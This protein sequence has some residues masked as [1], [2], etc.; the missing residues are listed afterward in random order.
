MAESPRQRFLREVREMEAAV[1]EVLSRGL[2]DEALREALEALARRRWFREFSW[3]WAPELTPRSRVLFR[4]FLLN[5]LSAW[6]LDAKGK[7]LEPWK[8]PE[9]AGTLQRLLDEADR[10]DDVELFRRLYAWRLR[11]QAEGKQAEAQWRQDLL[12][13]ARNAQGRVALNTVLAKLDLGL[14]ALDEPT[15]LALHGLNPV[16]TRAFILGHLP[17]E[18]G[19]QRDDP[20]R[21]WR[22]LLERAREAKDWELY[23]P[24]YR[25]LVPLDTWAQDAR[26][27]CQGMKEPA[28]LVEALELRHPEGSALDPRKTAATFLALA[29][30]RGRDVVPYLLKHARSIFPRWRFWGGRADA[31]GLP[32]LLELAR[33]QGWLDVWATLLRTSATSETWNG[34][35]RRLV[36]EVQSPGADV[37]HRLYQLAGVGSEFNGPGFSIAQVHPL[38]DAVAVA[39]YERFPDLMRGPYRMHASAWWAQGYPKLTA[40][41]LARQDEPL[42]DYLASRSALQPLHGARQQSP[43]AQTV[44]ALSQYFEA[45][46]EQDGTFARR[47]SNALAMMPAYAVHDY[48]ALLKSNRLAR[49]LFERSTDTYLSD[50]QAVRELLESPQLHVQALAFRV[51]GRP[52]ARARTLAARNEDLLQATLL[53]PLHRRTRR[54]AFA[55]LRNAAWADEAVARRLLARMKETLALPDRRYPKEGLVGLMAEVLHHW[56]S[57]REPSER[58]RIHGEAAP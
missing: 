2:G 10:R 7:P 46:P 28:L 19:L 48:G 13:R 44:D 14:Y 58:P 52:D 41:A 8:Q 36:A 16:G 38:E 12:T 43:W 54:M 5:H 32:Q 26:A 1:R 11:E 47:A 23:F 22:A 6:A 49:L 25:R 53:R 33:G 42:I 29:E 45:L 27:L 30:A 3:L 20:R 24:L 40:R 34:E 51:L 18:W 31:K 37:R 39:L 9:V 50:G 56:P 4:P 55:A 21:H 57:L 17:G 35:V 15:A